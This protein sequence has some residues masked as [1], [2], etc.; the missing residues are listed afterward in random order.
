MAAKPL[1]IVLILADQHRSDLVGWGD[2]GRTLTPNL[3]RMA[4]AGFRL[5]NAFCTAPLCCPSRAALASGRY[6]MNTGC[7]TNLHE[8]PPGTPSFVSRLRDAGYA[9]SAIGKT[10]MEIH[11]YDSD[12]TSAAHLDY[13]RSLGW[14]EVCE[15]SGNGMLKTGIICAYSEFLR[16]R[17][18]FED[19]LAYY[20]RWRYFMDPGGGFSDFHSEPWP[21]D[22]AFQETSFTADRALQWLD[23]A[24][25][26]RPFFL[27]VGFAAP[28]SPLE[29]HPRFLERY[30]KMDETVPVGALPDPEVLR[31]R[32]GYR[33]MI[34][35]VDDA[36]GRIVRQI[37]DLGLADR[38][39]IVYTADHG[40]MAGDFGQTGK[41]CFFE[42][43]VRIPMVLSGPGIRTGRSAALVELIDLGRTFCE[44][45]G[46]TPHGLDQGLSLAPLLRGERTEHRDDVYAEM[47][48]DRMLLDGRFKL[49]YGDPGLDK[50]PGLGRLHLDK[51]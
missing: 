20:R 43:S 6:G 15:V 2:N 45:G 7:F 25:K 37:R 12:L 28:H 41:T 34:T 30:R 51:P 1:N 19:V 5:D 22:E 31:A 9:T 4:A 50:R 10:H 44:L 32:T 14:D 39:L 35:Q 38:T 16:E 23:G 36:V 18:V 48:C 26:D 24:P 42:G 11:A 47:G 29:P 49:M 13:M 33:A 27:H 8:L 46:A 40:E 3:D 21:F 17:G